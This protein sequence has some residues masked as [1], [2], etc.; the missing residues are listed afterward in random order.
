MKAVLHIHENTL[1]L[2]KALSGMS[3]KKIPNSWFKLSP[4]P[5]MKNE[6]EHL[7]HSEGNL[8]KPPTNTELPVQHPAIIIKIT[9]HKKMP[10]QK[11][12]QQS[13]KCQPVSQTSLK[14]LSSFI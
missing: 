8:P 1:F 6:E 11:H 2:P 4:F 3:W 5:L 14:I 7:K 12:N 13:E 10:L 9:V